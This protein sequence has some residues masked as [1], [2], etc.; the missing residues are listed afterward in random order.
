MTELKLSE[1]FTALYSLKKYLQVELADFSIKHGWPKPD[2]ELK[3]PSISL[4]QSGDTEIINH[5]PRLRETIDIDDDEVNV[6]AR[7]NT[8]S[9]ELSINADIWETSK[10]RLGS[11]FLDLK[12]ALSKSQGQNIDNPKGLELELLGYFGTLARYDILRYN[13][14][15]GEAESQRSEYRMRVVISCHFDEI[16]EVEVSKMIETSIQHDISV[17]AN[18]GE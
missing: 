3:F 14:I 9:I 6:L 15:I 13:Y 7:Y 2:E 4:F 10:S 5:D 16:R 17:N 12:N 8:G 18:I 11:S 1:D